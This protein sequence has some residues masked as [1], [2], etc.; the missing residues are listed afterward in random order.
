MNQSTQATLFRSLPALMPQVPKLPPLQSITTKVCMD[1]DV[2]L[3]S[4]WRSAIGKTLTNRRIAE[5]QREGRYGS[6]L[7]LPPLD[8]AK[9]CI[10]CKSVIN[11][12]KMNYAYLPHA[13]VYCPACRKEHKA[14]R[15]K[16]REIRARL[17]EVRMEDWV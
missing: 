16:E 4:T 2:H 15:E 5:Y 6:G 17:R 11:T 3:P 12:R 7:K 10:Q 8:S 9:P 1:I 13:G 14:K